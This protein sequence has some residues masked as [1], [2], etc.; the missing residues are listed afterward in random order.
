MDLQIYRKEHSFYQF[1]ITYGYNEFFIDNHRS[2][3]QTTRI[4]KTDGYNEK[5]K[6]Q[7]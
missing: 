6:P 5:N 3:L 1:T 7:V 2:L 4:S